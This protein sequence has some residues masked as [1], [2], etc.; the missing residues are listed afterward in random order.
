MPR[1]IDAHI[2]V[3]NIENLNLIRW[4]GDICV[5]S[6]KTAIFAVLARLLATRCDIEQLDEES[7]KFLRCLI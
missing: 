4:N 2:R 6:C 1:I 5:A 7:R 3:L